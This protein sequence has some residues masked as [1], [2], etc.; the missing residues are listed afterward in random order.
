M[1]ASNVHIISTKSVSL[2]GYG[3]KVFLMQ[4]GYSKVKILY[5]EVVNQ[6]SPLEYLFVMDECVSFTQLNT[7]YSWEKLILFYS[8][9][10]PLTQDH[11]QQ[12]PNTVNGIWHLKDLR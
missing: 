3:L 7:Y 1:S 2:Y 9:N 8:P 6:H 12:L 10:F 5:T 11:L 4:K